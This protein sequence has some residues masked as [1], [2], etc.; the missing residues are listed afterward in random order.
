MT[1]KT[2]SNAA[3]ATPAMSQGVRSRVTVGL[4]VVPVGR[5]HP[6][7]NRAPGVSCA[8]QPAHA[9]PSRAE[10]QWEQNLPD[11]EAPQTG[12]GVAVALTGEPMSVK[13]EGIGAHSKLAALLRKEI[14]TK[15]LDYE[16]FLKT[17][18]KIS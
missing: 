3:S 14:S 2:A 9:V 7:Q 5:P 4:A 11:P 13:E 10:P 8:P 16:D 12:Q 1:S 17:S 6:E 15:S 18:M